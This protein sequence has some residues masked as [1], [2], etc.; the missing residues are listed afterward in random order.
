MGLCPGRR[1]VLPSCLCW[2]N[3]TTVSRNHCPSWTSAFG[4]CDHWTS[5]RV[6]WV[7]KAFT[8]CLCLIDCWVVLASH[9][10]SFFPPTFSLLLFLL[11][12]WPRTLG[13]FLSSLLASLPGCPH[14][15]GDAP[16][17]HRPDRNLPRVRGTSPASC[18][19]WTIW[20][21][22]LVS[23]PVTWLSAFLIW[24]RCEKGLF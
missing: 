12:M 6:P 5:A 24:P 16:M 4:I 10:W 2:E 3:H 1:L 23:S 22:H 7:R 13:A 21:W 11:C 20:R 19:L 14:T 9:K 15:S 8:W 18:A 17:A